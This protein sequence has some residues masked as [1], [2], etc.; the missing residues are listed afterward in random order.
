M[1]GVGWGKHGV[2]GGMVHGVI[3]ST[4]NPL[5]VQIILKDTLYCIRCY[6]ECETAPIQ[7]EKKS[8]LSSSTGS[9]TK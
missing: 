2:R 4:R 5:F 1:S 3:L 9:L 8:L 6:V 7:K